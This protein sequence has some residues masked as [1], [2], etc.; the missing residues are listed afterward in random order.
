MNNVLRPL[1]TGL[2]VFAFI[3]AGMSL[4]SYEWGW[5]VFFIIVGSYANAWQ[6]YVY[7]A[8]A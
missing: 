5:A 6:T 8:K 4:S 7:T 2:T 1:S 3:H